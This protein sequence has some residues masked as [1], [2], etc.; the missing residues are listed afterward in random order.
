VHSGAV[1]GSDGF[2]F[3]QD[4]QGHHV[5]IPQMGIVQ[6]DDDVEI[7]ANTT[8][9]RATL[10]K[11]WIRRG[12]K[13]DNLVQ[14]AHNVVVGEHSALIAQVGIAGSVQLGSHVVLA[15][16]TGVSGHVSIGDRVRVAAKSA[17][18]HA[19][20]AGEDMMGIPAIPIKEWMRIYGNIR[21]L[22][23]MRNQLRELVEKVKELE[24]ALQGNDHD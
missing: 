13:I 7:G 18:A 15:G 12:T 1:I 14:I 2:G 16:Q 6:I 5:K 19:V 4:E 21:R 24:Q 23:Q 22:P 20:A 17:V 8:I 10:G 11:T 3:A 9:D